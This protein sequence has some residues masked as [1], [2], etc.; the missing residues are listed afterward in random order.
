MAFVS[1]VLAALGTRSTSTAPGRRHAQPSNA[2]T[3]RPT[4]WRS[5]AGGDFTRVSLL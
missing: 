2:L 1:A 4:D 5:A 3:G